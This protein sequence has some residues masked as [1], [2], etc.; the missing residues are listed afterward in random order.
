MRRLQSASS[1][2]L[3][4]ALALGTGGAAVADEEAPAGAPVVPTAGDPSGAPPAMPTATAGATAQPIAAAS[5]QAPSS[6]AAKPDAGPP[7][8]FFAGIRLGFE[9]RSGDVTVDGS[10]SG[11]GFSMSNTVHYT[12]HQK[13]PLTVDVGGRPSPYVTLGA[14]ARLA[15][16][17]GGQTDRS[18]SAG[19]VV[20]VLPAPAASTSPWIAV[21]VGYQSLGADAPLTGLEI[22]PQVGLLFHRGNLAL[23]PVAELTL[24]DY[25]ADASICS[26]CSGWNAWGSLALRVGWM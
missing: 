26:S 9:A 25:S 12:G 14:Y 23:G 8:A 22:S 3:G 24:V 21:A 17:L 1:F 16:V 11:P 15:A 20:G 18:W 19:G 13:I 2:L 5:D 4:A 6:A 7:S 10:A